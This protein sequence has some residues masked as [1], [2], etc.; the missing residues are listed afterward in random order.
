MPSY[1]YIKTR[2]GIVDLEDLKAR[3]DL[4]TI[5]GTQNLYCPWHE[6][7]TTP[8]LHIYNNHTYC[9]ACGAVRDSISFV[10]HMEKLDFRSAIEFLTEY[11]GKERVKE[12]HVTNP[13]SEEE[14]NRLNKQLFSDSGKPAQLYLIGR[15]L[16]DSN[17]WWDLQLGYDF[18]SI[19]IPHFANGCCVNIKFRN[20]TDSG[21]KYNSM[22][23]REF[24]YLY[25]YDLFRHWYSNDKILYLT[26]GEFDCMLLL[27][28]ELPAMSLPAGANTPLENFIPFLKRFE[29]INLLFDLD[30][31]GQKAADRIFSNKMK[32]GYTIKDMC[33]NTMFVRHTW[34][35]EWGKDV[36]LAR[37][38]LISS[39]KED[40]AKGI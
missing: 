12:T 27:Q 26:E 20:L 33:P 18:C 31:A 40:Y 14:I 5:Y 28:E 30:E 6:D 3:T 19:T 32:T 34:N 38:K 39:L 29:R 37:E 10:M 35:K 16:N 36:T 15:G 4:R 23:N 8:N 25:P 2:K 21:P 13:I 1:N 17:Y 7:T 22:P 11:A 24:R 9:F